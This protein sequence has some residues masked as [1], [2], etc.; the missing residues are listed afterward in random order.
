VYA[1]A[2]DGQGI[3]YIGGSFTNHF[4]A[5]GDYITKW[6]GVAYSSLGTGMSDFVTSMMIGSDSYL[7]VGGFFSTAN[8]VT[9]NCITKWNGTTFVALSSGVS[10]GSPSAVYALFAGYD[11]KLY[12]GGVFTSAGG[13]SV[14]H[15]ASWNGVA[16]SSLGTGVGPTGTSAIW[17]ITSG[18]DGIVYVGGIFANAS[19]IILPDS[20]ASWS[21]ASWSPLD[22]DFPSTATIQCLF[23]DKIGNLYIC[24]NT[25]GSATS[26]TVTLTTNASTKTYPRIIFTGP[27]KC[28]QII[29]YTTGRRIY[30]NDGGGG[31]NFQAGERV[32][33]D[34]TPGNISFTSSWRGNLLNTVQNGSNLD[35]YLQGGVNN[36]SAYYASGTTTASNIF[37]LWHAAQWMY[38]GVE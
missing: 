35:F 2:I 8:G 3:L 27:G 1:L 11:S 9:V 17:S 37:T 16:Y 36:I 4:D 24:F 18:K 23:I 25:S 32:I 13:V 33:L 20:G 26:A 15:I 12:L 34:F 21:G 31:L 5:N 29:N 14:S 22:I 19:G 6:N 30:L 38:D 28:Y 7:Y 10:G